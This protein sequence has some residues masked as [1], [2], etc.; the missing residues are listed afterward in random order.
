MFE[1]IVHS[2]HKD[3][4]QDAV[5]PAEAS[6]EEEDIYRYRYPLWHREQASDMM[7]LLSIYESRV[8]D[9]IGSLC[10]DT[11]VGSQG[12]RQRGNSIDVC[13]NNLQ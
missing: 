1:I 3:M 13:Q 10:F 4:L 2:V 6:Q 9:T 5:V 7:Q 12:V 8:P 11:S